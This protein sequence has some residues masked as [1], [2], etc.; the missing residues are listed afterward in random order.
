[1][2]MAGSCLYIPHAANT[3]VFPLQSPHPWL[4]EASAEKPPTSEL[5]TQLQAYQ[6]KQLTPGPGDEAE[7]L[8]GMAPGLAEPNRASGARGQG[9]GVRERQFQ[10]GKKH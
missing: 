3:L 4:R 8:S 2:E 6:E 9:V 7:T 10:S 5:S 1:M